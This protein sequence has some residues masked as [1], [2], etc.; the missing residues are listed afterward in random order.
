MGLYEDLKNS[1][2]SVADDI[3][4]FLGVP[5]C[6][7]IPDIINPS[8]SSYSLGVRRILNHC[9]KF[10]AGVSSYGFTR[11]LYEAQPTLFSKLKHK[12]IYRAFKPATNKLCYKVDAVL[13][14]RK[15]LRIEDAQIKKIDVRYS[16]NNARLS[17][18]LHI[19]LSRYGY[20]INRKATDTLVTRA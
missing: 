13:K 15:R 17:D 5:S 19:A 18:L 8:L 3:F 1:P 11:D 2:Q 14:L 12:V 9:F 4:S 20:P 6:K 10:D 16:E 7:V